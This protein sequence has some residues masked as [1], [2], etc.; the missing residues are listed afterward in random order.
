MTDA[1]RAELVPRLERSITS[2]L[3][4]RAR[5]EQQGHPTTGIDHATK[6]Y[7]RAL[8]YIT[9]VQGGQIRPGT[10]TAALPVTSWTSAVEAM[11]AHT[12]LL[13]L[14]RDEHEAV[15]LLLEAIDAQADTG[16]FEARLRATHRSVAAAVDAGTTIEGST[17]G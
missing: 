1:E 13:N 8:N 3:V 4:A 17:D 10:F 6:A 2:C 9:G 15:A 11:K 12:R 16:Q 14:C 7:R 5:A